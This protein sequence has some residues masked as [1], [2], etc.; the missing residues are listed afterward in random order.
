MLRS[1]PSFSFWLMILFLRASHPTTDGEEKSGMTPVESGSCI[2]SQNQEATGQNDAAADDLQGR[3]RFVEQEYSGE[4]REKRQR[5]H[6][7]G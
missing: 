4:R 6:K 5:L 3:E 2:T 1:H 7:R